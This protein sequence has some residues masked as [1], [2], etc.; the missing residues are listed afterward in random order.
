MT[1]AAAAACLG[2]APALL[3]QPSAK[4]WRIGV[5]LHNFRLERL[6][7]RALLPEVGLEEGRNLQFEIRSTQ[8]QLDR[9][10]ALA[11]EL[12]AAKVD[13]IVA[14]NNTE[15]L[16]A[17]RATQSIPI[18]ML[19]AAAPVETGLVASLARPG[20]NVTGT[21][22]NAPELA[23]KMVEILRETVPRMSRIVFLNEPE[24]PGMALYQ[25]SAEQAAAAYGLKAAT[26]AVRGP[27]DIDEALRS[28]ERQRPDGVLV[29]T[30]GAIVGHYRR[31]VEF[32][33]VQRLP[34][35]YS[36]A[37]PVRDGGL[38]AYAPDFNAMAR[39]NVAMIDKI[40]KGVRPADI[41]VEEPAEFELVVN[42]KTARSLGLT[43]PTSILVRAS[44]VLQ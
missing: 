28:L 14:P 37:F 25:R 39:R 2:M 12:V 42:L 1:I 21:T 26:L 35:I 4:V 10:D 38:V 44:E 24:Y 36:T 20:G 3:A 41:P 5:L 8:G 23:G 6:R 43:V 32:M 22:T 30:T 33:A 15:V 7:L 27:A 19:F 11:A 9:L 13:L 40:L 17:K 16:A 34:A 18:L 31:I 29:A